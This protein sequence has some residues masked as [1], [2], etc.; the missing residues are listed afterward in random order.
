MMTLLFPIILMPWIRDVKF[1]KG[2]GWRIRIWFQVRSQP[3]SEFDKCLDIH[4]RA[5][6]YISKVEYET[7]ICKMLRKRHE[8]EKG[9]GL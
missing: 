9:A 3:R 5:S 4:Y 6:P 8:F 1:L 7:Y 2:I